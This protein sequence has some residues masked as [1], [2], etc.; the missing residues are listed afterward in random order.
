MRGE[1]HEAAARVVVRAGDDR[2][3]RLRL[4]GHCC[5]VFLV[6]AEPDGPAAGAVADIVLARLE[7]GAEDGM[8]AD[9][10]LLAHRVDAGQGPA[11]E[12]QRLDDD[13]VKVVAAGRLVEDPLDGADGGR[14]AEGRLGGRVGEPDARADHPGGVVGRPAQQV[15]RAA[16]ARVQRPRHAVSRHARGLGRRQDV[17]RPLGCSALGPSQQHGGKHQQ[18]QR[19]RQRHWLGGGG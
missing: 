17:A 12:V 13:P 2:I 7:V 1:A 4:V 5:P 3:D 9:G 19:P 14:R 8:A 10:D 15:Q 16:V 6:A 18:Q 11:V